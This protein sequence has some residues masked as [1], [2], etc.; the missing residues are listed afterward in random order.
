MEFGVLD[1]LHILQSDLNFGLHWPHR[2]PVEESGTA[3]EDLEYTGVDKRTIL[4]PYVKEIVF[5][6]VQWANFAHGRPQRL[7]LVSTTM[8]LLFP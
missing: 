4:K 6:N 7:N 1:L 2:S 5:D 8:N 3:T